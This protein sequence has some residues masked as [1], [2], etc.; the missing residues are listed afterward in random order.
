LQHVP[1]IGKGTVEE[2]AVLKRAG[3]M[4]PAERELAKKFR[5]TAAL[6]HVE[7]CDP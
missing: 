2:S 1:F 6:Q 4:H 5:Y 3:R 7:P